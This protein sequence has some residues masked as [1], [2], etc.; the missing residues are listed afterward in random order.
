MNTIHRHTCA[1]RR[2]VPALAAVASLAAGTAAAGEGG[3]IVQVAT[4]DADVVTFSIDVACDRGHAVVVFKNLGL[5]WSSAGTLTATY[6]DDP[7]SFTRHIRMAERQTAS[8][9]L[10]DAYADGTIKG[11]ITAPWLDRPYDVSKNVACS[12]S[13]SLTALRP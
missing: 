10:P 3:T 9:R 7:K 13:P 8:F 1:L 11:E 6:L 12:R 5:R 4:T 2:L